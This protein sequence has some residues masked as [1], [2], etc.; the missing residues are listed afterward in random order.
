VDRTLNLELL[1]R[2]TLTAGQGDTHPSPGPVTNPL[3]SRY[4]SA[5]ANWSIAEFNAYLAPPIALSAAASSNNGLTLMWPTNAAVTAYYTTSLTSP[6]TWMPVTNAPTIVN[7][8]WNVTVPMGTN[9]S[10][11]YRLH[12]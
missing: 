9:Q 3:Q 12:Y 11:F 6:I 1:N 8:Q 2:R 7:G 4:G 10:A 5:S